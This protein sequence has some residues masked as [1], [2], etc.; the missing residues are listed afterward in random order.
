[1]PSLLNIKAFIKALFMINKLIQK[2]G[3]IYRSLE[4]HSLQLL[5]SGFTTRLSAVSTF[6]LELCHKKGLH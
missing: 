1:M 6:P 3:T 2:S 5:T 4:Y